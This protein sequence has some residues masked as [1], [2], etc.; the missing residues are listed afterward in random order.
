MRAQ[1]TKHF[2]FCGFEIVRIEVRH[3][4]EIENNK[5]VIKKA[6]T[7]IYDEKWQDITKLFN[8]LAKDEFKNYVTE[9]VSRIEINIEQD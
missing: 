2:F 3:Y 1:D 9:F 8:E 5:P 7:K 6:E 4:F